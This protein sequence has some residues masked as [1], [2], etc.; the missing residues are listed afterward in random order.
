M[1]RKRRLG[2]VVLACCM[3]LMACRP[4]VDFSRHTKET[5]KQVVS[6]PDEA[7]IYMQN[8]ALM[9]DKVRIPKDKHVELVLPPRIISESLQLRSGQQIIQTFNVK[10]GK[11]T[12]VRIRNIQQYVEPNK[13]LIVEYLTWGLYWNARYRVD[14]LPNNQ[15]RLQLGA[16]IQNNWYNLSGMKVTLVAGWVGG[17][18]QRSA[19]SVQPG[20]RGSNQLASAVGLHSREVPDEAM[21]PSPMLA[22]ASPYLPTAAVR[23]RLRQRRRR[24]TKVARSYQRSRPFQLRKRQFQAFSAEVL[25]RYKIRKVDMTGSRRRSNFQRQFLRY[26]RK[27]MNMNRVSGY[28]LYHGMGVHMRQNE[29]TLRWVASVRVPT[30]TTYVWPADQGDGVFIKYNIK[31]NS[32]ILFPVGSAWMYRENVFVGQDVCLWTPMGAQTALLTSNDGRIAVNKRVVFRNNSTTR[33]LLTIQNFAKKSIEVEVFDTNPAW[34]KTGSL[35]F[36]FRPL[37]VHHNSPYHRWKLSVPASS[38]RQIV[39][40]YQP[41]PNLPRIQSNTAPSQPRKGSVRAVSPH[42]SRTLPARVKPVRK[43]RNRRRR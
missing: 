38:R 3:G 12:R 40:D 4:A 14:I 1:M 22:S 25:Q 19:S 9:R 42:H 43:R 17:A 6:V 27:A 16:Q 24:R 41:R 30:K 23:P 8:L 31:N 5:F 15:L 20:V 29:K 34:N 21:L 36:N 18:L 39:M 7:V 13:P 11:Y 28:A 37:T 2:L 35:S 33:I 26:Y 32:K 10:R